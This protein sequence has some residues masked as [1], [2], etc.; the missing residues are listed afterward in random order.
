MPAGPP[1]QDE[2]CQRH[3]LRLTN[4]LE[5]QWIFADADGVVTVNLHAFYAPGSPAFCEFK[6]TAQWAPKG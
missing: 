5:G 4:R 6:G 2:V 3:Y 1:C